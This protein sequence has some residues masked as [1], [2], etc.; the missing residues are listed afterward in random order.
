[1]PLSAVWWQSV[2]WRINE[3][4]VSVPFATKCNIVV[5]RRL[6]VWLTCSLSPLPSIACQPRIGTLGTAG[7]VKAC[8]CLIQ[9]CFSVHRPRQPPDSPCQ[10]VVSSAF[11]AHHNLESQ[12]VQVRDT[13]W[14]ARCILH[15]SPFLKIHTYVC[16]GPFNARKCMH[17]FDNH[18]CR[19]GM[20]GLL[21]RPRCILSLLCRRIRSSHA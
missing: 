5:F 14:P 20:P 6:S 3:I 17:T 2:R 16:T 9:A 11:I 12:R 19:P 15:V 18:T 21:S 7:A 4:C 8:I 10:H 13:A 1:M